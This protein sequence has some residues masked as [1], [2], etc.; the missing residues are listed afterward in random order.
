MPATAVPSADIATH[1]V[2]SG[3]LA[4]DV[5]ADVAR[6]GVGE[7]ATGVPGVA[8]P[9]PG[10][11]AVAVP[12]TVVVAVPGSVV[13]VVADADANGDGE[14]VG[15]GVGIGAGGVGV[16]RTPRR[17]VKPRKSPNAMIHA[18]LIFFFR[19]GVLSAIWEPYR[20]R[21]R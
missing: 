6:E 17:T 19:A 7:S 14:N 20:R 1:A 12:G 5:D 11:D 18:A 2:R 10:T 3:P 21:C 9:V 13:V 15:V 8:V 4:V 16:D